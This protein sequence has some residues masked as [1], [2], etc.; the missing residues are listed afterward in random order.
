[1]WASQWPRRAISLWSKPPPSRK[2][3]AFEG[4]RRPHQE[5][6]HQ[7]QASAG[8]P[9]HP[10]SQRPLPLLRQPQQSR[11]QARM[12]Q[13][14]TCPASDF[15]ISAGS[16]TERTLNSRCFSMGRTKKFASTMIYSGISLSA[17]ADISAWDKVAR[18]LESR[19]CTEHR[20][21]FTCGRAGTAEC[22]C[23]LELQN[24]LSAGVGSC[25]ET[26]VGAYEDPG[27]RRSHRA[28]GP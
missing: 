9:P 23:Q 27:C 8:L 5:E 24:S 20:C 16:H 18:L 11:N 2:D 3:L 19:Y 14:R 13:S 7:H 1:M 17:W 6:N 26:M 12:S 4:R 28:G 25:R 22:S 21:S 15:D 10:P